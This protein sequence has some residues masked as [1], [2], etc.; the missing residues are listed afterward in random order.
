M[1]KKNR[2]IFLLG[3]IAALGPLSIDLYLSSFPEIG[4]D[5]NTPINYVSLTL[6]AYFIG[7]SIGQLVN[8]PLLD[9]YG[10]KKPLVLG[11]GIYVISSLG[12]SLAPD[13][14]TLIGLRFIMA[15]GGSVGMVATRALI[16]DNFEHQ[17]I[18]RAFS[19]L[20]LVYG[21]A[22]I[23]APFLGSYV[24][25]TYGWR[26]NFVVLAVYALI[27]LLLTLKYLKDVRGPQKDYS[28]KLKDIAVNYA[29]LIRDPRFFRYALSSG[30][31]MMAMFA[32]I[33]GS[34]FVVREVLHFDA[35][36][37]AAV[38]GSNALAY[39]SASQVNQ[40]LLKRRDVLKLS[41]VVAWLFAILG[42]G[43][44]LNTALDIPSVPFFLF[45]FLLFLSLLGFINPN[46]QA[47]ALQPFKEQA[48]AAA[49]LI[50]ALRMLVGTLA[51]VY[52]SVLH[53]G[54]AWPMVS[55]MGISAILFF[56][57]LWKSPIIENE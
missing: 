5:L 53:D 6:T 57:S 56:A 29:S 52:I 22:P 28:L 23:L 26:A 46:M 15:L 38:F 32:Y 20:I 40:L 9:R 16:R 42:I 13:I 55:L 49:A 39:I 27:I 21:T 12:C 41:K 8:G 51:S 3:V 34:P 35:M 10:R 4:E 36:N 43:L 50:G 48:G 2:L 37:Y 25:K 18:A 31:G 11:I 7:I 33:S 19:M 44:V 45:N 1:E 54:T 47:L 14:Y 24:L 30:F 17:D